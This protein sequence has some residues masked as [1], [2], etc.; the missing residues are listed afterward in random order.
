VGVDVDPA[1][2]DKGAVGL[3]RALGRAGGAADL[4]QDAVVDGDVARRRR[5]ARPVDDAP[6]LDDHIVHDCPPD[7]SFLLGW[8]KA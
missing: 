5:R 4:R 1:G 7:R 3:D 8:G 6:A 2:S